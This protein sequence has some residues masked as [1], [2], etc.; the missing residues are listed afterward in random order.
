MCFSLQERRECFDF[1]EKENI[2]RGGDQMSD[3]EIDSTKIMLVNY[4]FNLCTLFLKKHT[5]TFGS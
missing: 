3:F 4:L 5:H 1:C 2:E